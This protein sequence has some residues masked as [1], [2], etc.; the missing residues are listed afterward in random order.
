[1]LIAVSYTHLVLAQLHF[2]F[3]KDFTPNRIGQQRQWAVSKKAQNQERNH[4]SRVQEQTA[5]G[6]PGAGE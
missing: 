4:A 6:T 2:L 1:M 5:L 3:S